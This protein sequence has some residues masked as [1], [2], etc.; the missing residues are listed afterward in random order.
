MLL[1]EYTIRSQIT[2]ARDEVACIPCNFQSYPKKM[3]AFWK[4]TA[5]P[6]YTERS[7]CSV[8][9]KNREKTVLETT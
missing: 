8:H 7:F 6:G 2:E 9:H 4:K 5:I 3:N 1:E